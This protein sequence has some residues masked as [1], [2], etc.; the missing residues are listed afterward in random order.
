MTEKTR[1]IVISVMFLSALTGLLSVSCIDSDTRIG[2]NADGSGSVELT[3]TVSPLVMSLG[4]LD[5]DNP[6]FPL[7]VSRDDFVRTASGISGLELGDYSSR[8]D[9]DGVH[10][11][12]E[13]TFLTADA[14]NEF[15]GTEEG[16][17]SL[18]GDAGLNRLR[19]VIYDAPDVEIAEESVTLAR[20][21]FSQSFLRFTLD[22]PAEVQSS[23]LGTISGNRRSITLELNTAELIIDNQDVIWEVTW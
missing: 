6:V 16:E 1:R 4:A 7:P 18:T 9:E 10:I 2:I 17:F 11:T 22:T 15:I 23:T 12:A 3:Y 20:D 14:L 19:Y 5:E 21:F 8:E 13:L